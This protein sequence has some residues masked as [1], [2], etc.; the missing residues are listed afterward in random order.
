MLRTAATIPGA[1]TLNPPD[2]GDLP[3]TRNGDSAGASSPI[4][5]LGRNCSP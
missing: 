3:P 1:E 4:D 5:L 2:F